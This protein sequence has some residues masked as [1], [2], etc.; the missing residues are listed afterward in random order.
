[1]SI[2]ITTGQQIKTITTK[3]IGD[4][5]RG[6]IPQGNNEAIPYFFLNLAIPGEEDKIQKTAIAEKTANK[7]LRDR[8][9]KIQ[10][11]TTAN[12]PPTYI[13]VE[14]WQKVVPDGLW[15]LKY[16]GKFERLSDKEKLED[17]EKRLNNNV[18]RELIKK[19]VEEWSQQG[20]EKKEVKL[21][22]TR[23]CT[24]VPL[25]EPMDTDT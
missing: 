15:P 12:E 1:M 21:I 20:Y 6:D 13:I 19:I 16:F 22:I 23:A 10:K 11:T 25:D 5:L 17:W 2:I 4:K 24:Y 14:E 18:R 8:Y 9:H 7:F 3:E